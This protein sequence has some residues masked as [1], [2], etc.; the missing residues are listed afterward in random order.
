MMALLA[1]LLPLA[2]ATGGKV[3]YE[4]GPW[5][6]ARFCMILWI[7]SFGYAFKYWVGHTRMATEF[8]AAHVV[9]TNWLLLG[10]LVAGFVLYIALVLT[11]LAFLHCAV[12]LALSSGR[13]NGAPATASS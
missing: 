8:K 1:V 4:Q 5:V 12:K 7:V 13:Q 2:V 11:P 3:C 10:G 6:F 9:I